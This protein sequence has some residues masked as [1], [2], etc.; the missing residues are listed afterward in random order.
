MNV[1]DSISNRFSHFFTGH[2]TDITVWYF[3]L[4]I[5]CIVG[6]ILLTSFNRCRLQS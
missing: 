1:V 5:G 3:I 4:G 2:F 6:G